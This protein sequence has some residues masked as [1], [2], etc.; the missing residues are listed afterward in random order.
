MRAPTKRLLPGGATGLG[1]SLAVIGAVRVLWPAGQLRLA[2]IGLGA[3]A[4][5]YVGIA[6]ARS[7]LPG[8]GAPLIARTASS[9]VTVATA[10]TAAGG[11][12]VVAGG[13]LVNAPLAA[14]HTRALPTLGHP[15][16][17][18]PPSCAAFDSLVGFALV[19]A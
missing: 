19:A 12:R 10:G 4:N 18:S 3:T 9:A 5:T 16:G 6:L 14:A 11:G 8:R 13:Y 1:A 2:V 17:W 15:P 7:D